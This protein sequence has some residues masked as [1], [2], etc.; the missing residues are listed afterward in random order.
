MFVPDTK[1]HHCHQPMYG[2]DS[3]YCAWCEDLVDIPDISIGRVDNVPKM[4]METGIVPTGWVCPR[5][6]TV[7]APWRSTCDCRS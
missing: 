1:C 6:S 5:C 2:R 3:M 7:N 4:S